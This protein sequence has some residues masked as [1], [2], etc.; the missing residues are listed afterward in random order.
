MGYV[1]AVSGVCL[2][3]LG[4]EIIGVDTNPTKADLINRG[5]AP[6]VETGV[7]ARIAAARAEGRMRATTDAEEAVLAS[8]ISMIS[9]GTPSAESGTPMLDALDAVVGDIGRVLRRKDG[10]HTMVVRSTVLP[11]TTEERVAPALV[12]ASGRALG[13]GLEVCFNP[14]F[15]REGSAIK[16]FFHPPFTIAGCTSDA[17]FA[18][19]ER[20]Y[21]GLDAPLLRAAPR[22]AESLKYVCNAFHAFKIAF[23]NEMGTLLKSLGMD[24]R[25]TMRIFC[26]D[27]ELNISPAYLRPGFAFGGSCLPKELRALQAL[28]RGHHIELPML[29]QILNSNQRH[30]DQA[31]EMIARRGRG[32]VAMFGLAFKPGTDDLRESP[33]VR[34][35]ER[36]IGKGYDLSIFDRSVEA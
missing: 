24:S 31:F 18:A 13:D 14:E 3:D 34:L 21:Q 19:L 7:A 30:I 35:A 8:D 6:I 20:L 5:Q 15:L 32:K 36:L 28:A 29:A 11:G 1:G 23:A 26:E 17:G 16:D 27:R 10:A 12:E 22:V 2:S 9:V 33:L 25:E 4:H